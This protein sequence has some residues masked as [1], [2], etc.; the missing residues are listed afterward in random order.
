MSFQN[1]FVTEEWRRQ[2]DER[3]MGPN[4]RKMGTYIQKMSV[5]INQIEAQTHETAT[6]VNEITNN[7]KRDSWKATITLVVAILTFIV[8]VIA[9]CH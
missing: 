9:L 4:I 5:N 7:I 3:N 6:K 8:S 2:E 1:N